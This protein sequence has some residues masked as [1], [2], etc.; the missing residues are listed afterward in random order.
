MKRVPGSM[1]LA[2]YH[3]G[4]RTSSYTNRTAKTFSPCCITVRPQPLSAGSSQRPLGSGDIRAKA[5][6]L[7][8]RSRAI[9]QG[10]K[11]NVMETMLRGIEGA[12]DAI[13]AD[14]R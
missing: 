6:P 12:N 1:S 13:G 5:P 11:R 4:F 8:A 10:R 14:E 2:T 7:H 3:A 9:N